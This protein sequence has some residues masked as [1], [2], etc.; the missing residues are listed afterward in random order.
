[1]E[2]G[3][4]HAANGSSVL[5]VLELQLV[6]VDLQL[7]I[8]E[9]VEP[10]HWLRHVTHYEPLGEAVSLPKVKHDVA[11]PIGPDGCAVGRSE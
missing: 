9:E 3:G 7:V 10:E 6:D 1:M 11:V 2:F 8:L 5:F 4:G